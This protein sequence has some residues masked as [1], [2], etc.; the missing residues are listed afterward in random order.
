MLGSASLQVGRPLRTALPC[1]F[2]FRHGTAG[3]AAAAQEQR[4]IPI[5]TALLFPSV[6]RPREQ[7][8]GP[9]HLRCWIQTQPEKAARCLPTQIS[10]HSWPM[11]ARFTQQEGRLFKFI[12]IQLESINIDRFCCS[13][14][15]EESTKHPPPICRRV[16]ASTST[17][18]PPLG[19]P[20]L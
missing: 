11:T 9:I 1:V 4:R 8:V 18:Q 20:V 16:G 12:I 7:L 14:S 2:N 5:W 3:A 10:L 13:M 17:A 15:S 6:A 19:M